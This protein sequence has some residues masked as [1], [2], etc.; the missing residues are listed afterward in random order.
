MQLLPQSK[1]KEQSNLSI[2]AQL[3]SNAVLTTSPQLLFQ[4]VI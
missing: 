3:D 4:V 1:P 2:G